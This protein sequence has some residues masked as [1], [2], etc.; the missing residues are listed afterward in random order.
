MSGLRFWDSMSANLSLL[1]CAPRPSSRRE[2]RC[3]FVASW[4]AGPADAVATDEP[5]LLDELLP[6][7]LLPAGVPVTEAPPELLAAADA[8]VD[9]ESSVAAELA[10]VPPPHAANVASSAQPA[11]RSSIAWNISCA[12]RRKKDGRSR[13]WNTGEYQ[14]CAAGAGP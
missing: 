7:E 3:N 1:P 11:P 5:L 4:A 9:V 2:G 14:W 8:P 10:T 6:E 12:C 13:L